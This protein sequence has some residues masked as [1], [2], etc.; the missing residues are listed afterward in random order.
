MLATIQLYLRHPFLA[1]TQRRNTAAASHHECL[2]E[3]GAQIAV[4]L[5]RK[6]K[7][8][9][10]VQNLHR[11]GWPRVPLG[12]PPV[13]MLSPQPSKA[14]SQPRGSPKAPSSLTRSVMGAPSCIQ[15]RSST[16]PTR[17]I[18]PEST[19][20][21]SNLRLRKENEG[22]NENGQRLFRTWANTTQ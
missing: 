8:I 2:S 17:R 1:G 14:A 12:P 20:E 4:S 15:R 21:P 11:A 16:Q 9:I 22:N 6:P 5:L 13:G 3:R 18:P 10:P 7:G 19:Y